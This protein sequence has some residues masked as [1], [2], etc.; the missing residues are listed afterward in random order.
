MLHHKWCLKPGYMMLGTL[1]AENDVPF[2]A[3]SC[4][5]IFTACA[6]VLARQVK[7]QELLPLGCRCPDIS[8]PLNT[9]MEA[10]P[11]SISKNSGRGWFLAGS[12]SGHCDFVPWASLSCGPERGFDPQPSVTRISWESRMVMPCK[13]KAFIKQTGQFMTV[14]LTSSRMFVVD[15]DEY[16]QRF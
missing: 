12:S 14:C 6:W 5:V 7:T 8:R 16:I 3:F 2:P 4:V 9:P 11:V 10:W 1:V 15:L 13:V